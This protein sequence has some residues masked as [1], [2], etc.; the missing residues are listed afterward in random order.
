MGSEIR[1]AQPFEIQ[2]NPEKKCPNFEWSSLQ[3]VGNKAILK[4]EPFENWTI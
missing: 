2:T 1:K 3:L 4:A